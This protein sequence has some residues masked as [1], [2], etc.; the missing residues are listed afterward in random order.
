MIAVMNSSELVAILDFFSQ[1]SEK[2][3]LIIVFIAGGGR[4]IKDMLF[5][6]K[7]VV[8][9]EKPSNDHVE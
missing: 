3:A 1:H 7:N 4:L 9:N 5:D 2:I 8:S 6:K